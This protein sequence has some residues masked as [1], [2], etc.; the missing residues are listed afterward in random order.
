MWSPQYSRDMDLLEHVQRKVI[1]I[2][3]GMEQ[4]PLEDR[5]R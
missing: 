2:I 4:L 5:L 3:Q 1:K